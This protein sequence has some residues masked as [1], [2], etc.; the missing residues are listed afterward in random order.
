MVP[1]MV[2]VQPPTSAVNVEL[3]RQLLRDHPSWNRSRLSRE[4]AQRWNWRTAQGTL[5]DIACRTL[6]LK[7]ERQGHIRLP[8]PQRPANNDYR[9]WKLLD[10]PHA[11]DPIVAT[12]DQLRPLHCLAAHADSQHRNLVK[13]LLQRY[14]YLGYRGSPGESIWYL[15]YDRQ[16]RLLGCLLFGCAAWKVQAR[17]QFIGWTPKQRAA[18]LP[19][20]VNNQRFLI[21]PWVRCPHLASHALS[22]AARGVSDQYQQR[23]GHPVFLLETFVDTERFRGT[24]YRAANWIRLGPTQGRGRNDGRHQLRVPVKDVYVRP[25]Q[26]DF[27]QRLCS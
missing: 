9:R 19:V 7:L 15:L 11:R 16:Q 14:H 24:C 20:V 26:R 13:C 1:V 5:R 27:Q 8:P 18:N 25:L 2:N 4:L 23:Y 6:L 12:L 22:L 10:V 17:D 3:V 21:L